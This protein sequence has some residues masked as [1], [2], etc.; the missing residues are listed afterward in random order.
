MASSR[1]WLSISN[2][3]RKKRKYL[4]LK[5]KLA[6]EL[7][8]IV[9][10]SIFQIIKHKYV[11]KI[12]KKICLNLVFYFIKH[13]KRSDGLAFSHLILKGH[14]F[15]S[16]LASCLL[17]H[18]SCQDTI[19]FHPC[20]IHE[21]KC[22]WG[23]NVKAKVSGLACNDAKELDVGWKGWKT[24]AWWKIDSEG[25]KALYTGLHWSR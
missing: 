19:D 21:G 12:N 16:T 15:V 10:K 24:S 5:L 11:L 14:L 3:T 1:S 22:H 2:F 9:G 25:N 4:S 13:K 17:H 23:Q 6:D 8:G 7:L 20:Y 18:K